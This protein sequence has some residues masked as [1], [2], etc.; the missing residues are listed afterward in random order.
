LFDDAT[1]A[2]LHS[3][4]ALIIGTVDAEGQPHAGR[5]WGLDLLDEDD[6]RR[7]EGAVAARLLVDADDTVT[8]DNLAGGCAVAITATS[9]RTLHSLQLKGRG[10]G[11]GRALPEDLDRAARFC[12]LF[13]TDIHETDHTDPVVTRR[14]TPSGYARC[15]FTITEVYDQTPGPRAG[16]SVIGPTGHDGATA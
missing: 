2:F 12:E 5:G 13:Y 8:I 9:V 4:C 11:V 6:P 7:P 1:A 15:W 3:G 10:L 16:A 14:M